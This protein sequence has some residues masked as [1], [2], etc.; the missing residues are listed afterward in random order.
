MGTRCERYGVGK[1]V[2]SCLNPYL[3]KKTCAMFLLVSAFAASSF[4]SAISK[5]N[6]LVEGLYMTYEQ[7]FVWSSHS[8]TANMTWQIT[9]IEGANVEARVASYTVNATDD[10]LNIIPVSSNFAV[11]SY[12]REIVSSSEPAMVGQ[13]WTFW[14]EK[15]VTL[16]SSVDT[17]FGVASV[18]GSETMFAFGEQ[19]GTWVVKY[20]WSTSSMKRWYDIASG[21]VLKIYV[22]MVKGSTQVQVT[23]T[24]RWT[25]ISLPPS[26]FGPSIPYWL[27]PL[28]SVSVIAVV[29]L[30]GVGVVL[31]S[32]ARRRAQ[33]VKFKSACDNL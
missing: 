1:L 13:R 17:G 16:G 20:E 32:R 27:W 21:I 23:E 2:N 25:N 30:V 33:A 29:A 4:P 8:E 11:N 22:A 6:W 28:A 7:V 10:T 12:T 3:K 5:P 26:E 9:G 14:I 15:N 19:R 18:R 24:A 31:K